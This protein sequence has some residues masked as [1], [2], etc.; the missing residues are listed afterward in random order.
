MGRHNI[1]FRSLGYERV[2]R[3]LFKMTDTPLHIQGDLYQRGRLRAS[4]KPAVGVDYNFCIVAYMWRSAQRVALREINVDTLVSNLST[5]PPLTW[6]PSHI[7]QGETR[8]F[9]WTAH[10]GSAGFEPGMHAWLSRSKEL[11]QSATS[12][13]LPG[14]IC[15]RPHY[16]PVLSVVDQAMSLYTTQT[17][18]CIDDS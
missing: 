2:Y 8:I 17:P 9:L 14:S 3:P 18:G 1:T 16:K 15:Q 5:K 10:P 4:I 7:D 6:S 13:S 12:P 11:Y